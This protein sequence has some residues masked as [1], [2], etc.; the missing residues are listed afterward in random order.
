VAPV[1]SQTHVAADGS[2]V[3]GIDPLT[4]LMS[5]FLKLRFCNKA[6]E[7]VNAVVMSINITLQRIQ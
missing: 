5:K 1:L 3:D 7:S 6:A 2:P 4:N